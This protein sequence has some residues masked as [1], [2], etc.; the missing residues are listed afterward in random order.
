[1]CDF[2]ALPVAFLA[3]TWGTCIVHL[4]CCEYLRVVDSILRYSVLVVLACWLCAFLGSFCIVF[5]IP[6]GGPTGGQYTFFFRFAFC[7]FRFL[8]RFIEFVCRACRIPYDDMTHCIVYSAYLL[9]NNL[10]Q[11][12]QVI[13]LMWRTAVV[14]WSQNLYPFY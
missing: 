12:E 8:S 5:H 9:H 4:N 10:Q 2:L 7:L 6:Y 13:S 11:Y 3:K 1:M 14:L